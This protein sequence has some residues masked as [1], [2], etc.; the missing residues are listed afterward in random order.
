MAVRTRVQDIKVRFRL[1][2]FL[3]FQNAPNGLSLL[4]GKTGKVG[5]RPLHNFLALAKG[6]TQ[7]NSG[8]R[9]AIG[10]NVYV[11]G[12]ILQH[13]AG[14]YMLYCYYYMGT[15]LPQIS[16]NVVNMPKISEN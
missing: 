5:N 16:R 1:N 12:P 13:Y 4:N 11:H 15:F 2:Q 3:A 14:Y 6:F 8:G 10:H 9:F 7:E